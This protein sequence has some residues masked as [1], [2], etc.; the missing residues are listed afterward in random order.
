MPPGPAWVTHLTRAGVGVERPVLAALLAGPDR[1]DRSCPCRPSYCEQR[2]RLAEVEVGPGRLG[3]VGRRRRRT[4]CS[5]PSR[6]RT[7]IARV[8]HRIAPVFMSSAMI[9]V[10]V[11]VGGQARRAARPGR[12]RRPRRSRGSHCGHVVVV[13]RSRCR[14]GRAWCRSPGSCP[15]PRCPCSPPGSIVRL[16]EDGAR[17]EVERRACCPGT[18]NIVAGHERCE[19]LLLRGTRR[20]RRGRRRPSPTA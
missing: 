12:R 6:R 14:P 10:E 19:R 7:A 3:T 13:A 16:P 20:R 9:A 15:R 17:V 18:S 2:R 4:G 1:L 5:R 8:A 11:V